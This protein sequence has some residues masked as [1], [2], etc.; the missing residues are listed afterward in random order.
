MKRNRLSNSDNGISGPS[1]LE[2]YTEPILNPNKLDSF[3]WRRRIVSTLGNAKFKIQY[4]GALHSEWNT[5]IVG[6]EFAPQKIVLVDINNQEEI[7]L[8]DACKHGYNALL[9]DKYTQEQLAARMTNQLYQ[10]QWG[11]DSFEIIIS[12]YYQI[13]F[14]EEFSEEIDVNGDVELINGQKISLEMLKRNA[15]DC[16]QIW[17]I[18]K[19]GKKVEIISEELA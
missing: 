16:I 3:E 15:Y 19:D 10:D 18:N 13:N 11:N 7:L 12:V 1:H 4:Y 9:C 14:E 6:T 5:L 17:G 8:F 2:M